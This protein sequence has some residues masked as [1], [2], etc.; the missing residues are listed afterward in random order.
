MGR[1]NL[2]AVGI[3]EVRDLLGATPER[4][5]R[6]RPL[7]D[8]LW[9]AREPAAQPAARIGLWARLTGRGAQ[10]GAPDPTSP[11]PADIDAVLAGRFVGPDRAPATWR[12]LEGLV[13]RLAHASLDLD[14]DESGIESFDYALAKAGAP[15]DA[16]LG[17]LLRSDARLGLTPVP[18]R[19][20]AYVSHAAALRGAALLADLTVDEVHAALAERLR[21]F[22]GQL[23]ALG[24]RARAEGRPDPDV[25]AF[26]G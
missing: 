16:G 13:G 3:D 14:L 22:L 9:P 12:V 15:A 11:T 21:D 6:V 25:V 5:A 2:Y 10:H 26:R 19:A 23:P 17:R 20:A 1:V 7:A 18:G 24:E 4:A 8:Q